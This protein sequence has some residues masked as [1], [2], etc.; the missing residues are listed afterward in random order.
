MEV[1]PVADSV[2]E[3]KAENCNFL[4]LGV[5]IFHGIREEIYSLEAPVKLLVS[6]RPDFHY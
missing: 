4:S 3:Y 2:W 1:A 5:I 6:T